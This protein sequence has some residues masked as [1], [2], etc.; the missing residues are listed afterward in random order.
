M[1]LTPSVEVSADD[2]PCG[3]G[4]LLL[5]SVCYSPPAC[6]ALQY[7]AAKDMYFH[8]AAYSVPHPFVLP[9][10]LSLSPSFSYLLL[11]QLVGALFCSEM[12]PVRLERG[13]LVVEMDQFAGFHPPTYLFDPFLLPRREG[14][15]TRTIQ[16]AS[17][18]SSDEPDEGQSR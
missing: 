14:S 18:V 16:T 3:Y 11:S 13:I 7:V 12:R 8:L 2:R 4:A 5:R 15:A 9:V 6:R 17:P 10:I 1:S